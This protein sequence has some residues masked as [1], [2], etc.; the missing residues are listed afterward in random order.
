MP[1][2]IQR[3]ASHLCTSAASSSKAFSDVAH[4]IF[5]DS[6]DK[7]G[8]LRRKRE[9]LQSAWKKGH[10]IVF[11]A[12]L[13]DYIAAMPVEELPG[14]FERLQSVLPPDV[15]DVTV[16]VMYR[17]PRSSHLISAWKQQIAMVR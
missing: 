17:T 13:F 16:A 1:R 10:S 4:S 15:K 8:I 7:N 11:G 6:N 14:A 12:E 2:A 3:Q 5:F 9:K